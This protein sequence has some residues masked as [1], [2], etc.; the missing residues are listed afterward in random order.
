MD[1]IARQ[2]YPD[3]E[4]IIVDGLST[5]GTLEIIKQHQ[6][7]VAYFVSEPDRGI[8]DAINKG[9]DK[10]TGDI[11][12]LLNSDDVLADNRVIEH[13]VKRFQHK[14]CDVVYGNLIYQIGRASCR[15]RV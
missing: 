3:I 15:E 9:L 13:I 6:D 5:D 1:S 10:A 11:I 2:T 14:R 4:H 7:K 12:G 8:Y